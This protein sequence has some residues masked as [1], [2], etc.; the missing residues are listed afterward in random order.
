[1]H[2]TA[3]NGRESVDDRA[4]QIEKQGGEAWHEGAGDLVWRGAVSRVK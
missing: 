2:V 4:V 3:M 1:V